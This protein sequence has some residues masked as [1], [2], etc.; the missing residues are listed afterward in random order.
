MKTVFL[1]FILLP[2]II[3]GCAQSPDGPD[4]IEEK[5]YTLEAS[6]PDSAI[7]GQR[8]RYSV[9]SYLPSTCW[10][11]DRF[12]MS[13]SGLDVFVS[14]FMRRNPDDLICFDVVTPVVIEGIFRSKRPG[15]YEFH[16]WRRDTLSLDDTVVVR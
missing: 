16:F 3:V 4:W 11:Y 13:S 14:L 6:L 15:D 8:I 2:V 7:V 1:L 12:E 9:R 5:M 10:E